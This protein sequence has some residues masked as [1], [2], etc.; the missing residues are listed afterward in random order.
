MFVELINIRFVL[1]GHNG[2]LR[3]IGLRSA[4]QSLDAEQSGPD[5]EGRRPLVFEDVE[6][7]GT[8]DGT[9][10]RVPDF[11]VEL[12]LWGLVRIL[13]RDLDVDLELA[14]LVRGVLLL[15]LFWGS[16]C[17]CDRGFPVE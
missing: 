17:S 6:A 12:H 2:V 11:C 13:V 10:I 14:L 9:D 8:G 1:L 16:Y 3:V 4:H 7:D 15:G 5:A